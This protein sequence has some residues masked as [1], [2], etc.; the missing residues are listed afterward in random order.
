MAPAPQPMEKEMQQDRD[1]GSGPGEK[2]VTWRDTLG[3]ATENAQCQLLLMALLM[4]DICVIGTHAAPSAS[5][6]A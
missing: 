4:V 3:D 6:S 2:E 1:P 5:M